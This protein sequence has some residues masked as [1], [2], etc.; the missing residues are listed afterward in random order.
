VRYRVSFGALLVAVLVAT[1]AD[2]G[3]AQ[4]GQMPKPEEHRA[5][6]WL[7][8]HGQRAQA[9][10]TLCA[11]CHARDYCASCHVNA[12][13]VPQ[14]QALPEDPRVAEYVAS[15]EWPAPPTHT[16]FYLEDHRAVAASATASCA[17]CHVIEQ[18]CETC[19]LGAETLERPRKDVA[20]YHPFD[21]MQQHSTAAWNRE[22][23]CAS[24]HNTQVFC[25]DCHV[26]LG[27]GT[28]S[29]TVGRTNTGYHNSDSDFVFGHGQAARQ[30]LETCASCHAQQ[31]CL[32]CHS[33]KIG[34][35]INPHGP[36]FD[37]ERLAEKNQALCLICH[38]TVPVG[39]NLGRVNQRE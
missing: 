7:G 20:L 34:R 17:T 6:D 24:C 22:T 33:A 13:E 18:Q 36:S 12:D 32:Q 23:E 29:G 15:K 31:D 5:A 10:V 3:L 26:Q 4:T 14:I 1:T 19:H 25:Q 28:P 2:Y 30:G 16:P 27:Y 35:N 21:F 9:D 8:I 38:F 37:A 11:V 39:S